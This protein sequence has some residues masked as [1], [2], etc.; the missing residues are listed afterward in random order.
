M[1]GVATLAAIMIMAG[2][3]RS[4][5]VHAVAT[6]PLFAP[7]LAVAGSALLTPALAPRTLLAAAGGAL[8]GTIA[9][10]A[11]VV[12]GVTAGAVIAF[13][14]GRLLGRDFV[15]ARLGGR[16]AQVEHAITRHGAMAV[17]VSRLI[18][19]VPFGVANYAFGTTGVGPVRFALGTLVGVVPATLAYAALGAAAVRGN[20]GGIAWA[21]ASVLALGTAGSIGTYLVW[22][23]RPGTRSPQR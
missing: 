6:A 16:L 3:T 10:A 19:L 15:A 2:P 1:A 9:G 23:H 20:A 22:R 4:G 14:I 17:L 8:F 18:P 7:A 5:L 12:A 11:Y 13:V 21:T